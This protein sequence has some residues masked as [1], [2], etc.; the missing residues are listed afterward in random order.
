MTQE[1]ESKNMEV[2]QG[3]TED[4][5]KE[6]VEET[7]ED[8]EEEVFIPEEDKVRLELERQL[9]EKEAELE[10][11]NKRYLR[12]AADFENF[13]RRMRQEMEEIRRFAAR[14]L[15]QELLPV[16]DNFERALASARAVFPE[17]VVTGIDMIYR[18]FLNVLGQNGLEPI[19][20]V[21]KQFDPVY[22]EAF[23]QVDTDQ[24]PDG[25]V[26][27]EVR[28]GYLL[29]GK[30]L[31]PALVKVAKNSAAEETISEQKEANTEI[32]EKEERKD[33]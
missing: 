18:Q 20:A 7:A 14:D 24:W 12:L 25:S 3:K 32:P 4:I 6:V 28:K 33:E 15:L 23:E 2:E 11:V 17:N 21:G 31:R 26:I 1:C 5:D 13:R 8:I 19:E 22:H 29:H 10:E 16:L 9:K 27:E 30:V